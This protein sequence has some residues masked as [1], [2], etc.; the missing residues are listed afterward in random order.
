[1]LLVGVSKCFISY[2]FILYNGAILN[3]VKSKTFLQ[4]LTALSK[5]ASIMDKRIFAIVRYDRFSFTNI[6]VFES[7]NNFSLAI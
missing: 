3:I 4:N 6:I 2:F 5:D 7:L 1:M